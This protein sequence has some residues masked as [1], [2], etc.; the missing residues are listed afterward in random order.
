MVSLSDSSGCIYDA[1]GLDEE[2]LAWVERLKN[3][4]GGRIGEY[5]NEFD[6]KYFEG[7]KPW[8]LNVDIAMP[9]ATQNEIDNDDAKTL[10]K[11]KCIAVVEGA[12]MPTGN[13]A[14]STFIEAGVLFAPAKAANA[15]GVAMSGLE[16]SQT[17]RSAR[18]TPTN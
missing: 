14:I 13:D 6:A 3:E 7:K 15:G 8:H 4:Q 2:K 1:N 10:I 5:A 18:G 16:M 17:H 11:N 12:N 9:C